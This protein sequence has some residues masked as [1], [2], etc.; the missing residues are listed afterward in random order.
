MGDIDQRFLRYLKNVPVM[1]DVATKIMS[2]TDENAQFS[3]KELESVIKVDPGLSVKILKIAN[4]ALYARQR[5]ITNIQTAITLLGFKNLK[6]LVLLVTASNLL[7]NV[8]RTAFYRRFWSQSVHCAFMSRHMC[9]RFGMK[10]EAEGAFTGALLHDI[11]QVAF[12]NTDPRGYDDLL[13]RSAERAQNPTGERQGGGL[14]DLERETFGVDHRQ[15]GAS[16][17]ESWF[18][19]QT[20]VDIAREHGSKNI[21]SAHKQIILVISIADIVVDQL[22]LGFGKGDLTALAEILPASP[23]NEEDLEYYRNNYLADIREDLLFQQ[24][25]EMFG[26]D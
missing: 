22:G 17:F 7:S 19:P 14:L 12:Y 20:F 16:V 6:S 18:F 10:E 23:I 11:G 2:M 25:R 1:P 13:N 5:E 3:F 15:L 8:H 24:C 26:I 9:L 21:V 4:S